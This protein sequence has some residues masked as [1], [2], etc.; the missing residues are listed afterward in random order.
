MPAKRRPP[1]W[2]SNSDKK[3]LDRCPLVAHPAQC[4]GRADNVLEGHR[5]K[6]CASIRPETAL[7]GDRVRQTHQAGARPAKVATTPVLTGAPTE[8]LMEMARGGCRWGSP[9]AITVT[10]RQTRSTDDVGSWL[11]CPSARWHSIPMFSLSAK[12][13]LFRPSP[14][15]NGAMEAWEPDEPSLRK[16]MHAGKC[17]ARTG[18]YLAAVS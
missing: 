15:D 9:V 8:K 13:V 16:A 11:S 17:C 14:K 6:D 12:S 4:I 5:L 2:Q 3:D 10:P 7:V 1:N 18:S